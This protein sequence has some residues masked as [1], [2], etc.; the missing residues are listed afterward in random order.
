MLNINNFSLDQNTKNSLESLNKLKT[1]IDNFTSTEE[2]KILTLKLFEITNVNK[3]KIERKL[4]K[5]L[6]NQ[7]I[8]EK[9]KFSNLTIFFAIIFETIIFLVL[10]YKTFF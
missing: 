7:F 10:F 4:K 8:Y 6:L 1:F 2:F 9:N 5:L 3:E